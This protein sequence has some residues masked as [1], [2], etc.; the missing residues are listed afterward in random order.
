MKNQKYL[1]ILFLSLASLGLISIMAGTTFAFFSADIKGKTVNEVSAP[2]M[3]VVYTEGAKS[4]IGILSDETAI[5]NND[6][7][8]FSL[9]AETDENSSFEYYVYL[10]EETE[11][12]LEKDKIK[13]YLTDDTNI[14]ASEEYTTEKLENGTFCYDYQTKKLYSKNDKEYEN[15]S[16]VNITD[17]FYLMD[18][19]YYNEIKNDTLLTCREYSKTENNIINEIVETT[20]CRFGDVYKANP[21]KYTDLEKNNDL[22]ISNIIYKGIYKNIDGNSYYNDIKSN[23]KKTFRLKLWANNLKNDEVKVEQNQD[24]QEIKDAKKTFKYKVNVYAKQIELK[25]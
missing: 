11:N 21:L 16:N 8:E 12:T 9:K 22:N 7:F 19:M 25:K 3:K 6:Y 5:N 2:A 13:V 1:L 24:G 15:C 14:P 18:K 23:S 4:K 20:K 10:T 17:N